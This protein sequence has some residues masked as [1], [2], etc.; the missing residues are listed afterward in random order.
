M[1]LG[2]F[3]ERSQSAYGHQHPGGVSGH[4]KGR[5]ELKTAVAR[6]QM[7]Q[8]SCPYYTLACGLAPSF[9]RVR[10]AIADPQTAA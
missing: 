6:W 7:H 5:R 3:P 8:L 9:R 10:T 1:R 4:R 2:C